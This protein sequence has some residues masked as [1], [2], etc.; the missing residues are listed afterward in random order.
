MTQKPHLHDGDARQQLLQFAEQA[1][2]VG[3]SRM[4][5]DQSVRRLSV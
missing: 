2:H 3:A 4:V 1:L 5:C